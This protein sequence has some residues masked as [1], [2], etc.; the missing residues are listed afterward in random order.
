MPDPAIG[1]TGDQ[2]IFLGLIIPGFILI[3][4]SGFMIQ[5][6]HAKKLQGMRS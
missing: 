5:K 2:Q 4:L 1:A 3:Y 6:R